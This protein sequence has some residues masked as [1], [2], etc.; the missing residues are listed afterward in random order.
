MYEYYLFN[1]AAPVSYQGQYLNYFARDDAH[2]VE[3]GKGYARKLGWKHYSIVEFNG[4]EEIT[5]YDISNKGVY[6]G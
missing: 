6:Y 3:L 4:E 5:L 1:K 2:A